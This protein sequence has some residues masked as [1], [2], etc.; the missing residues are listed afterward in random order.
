M[1]RQN[2]FGR[3]RNEFDFQ[4]RVKKVFVG[5][6]LCLTALFLL[7]QLFRFKTDSGIT[8]GDLVLDVC[9]EEEF[10]EGHHELARHTT[11]DQLRNNI[12]S[13]T[14]DKSQSIAIFARTE[15]NAKEACRILQNHGFKNVHNLGVYKP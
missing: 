14:K 2:R 12:D 11:L 9:T 7:F 8:A 1:R 6:L 10:R 3:Q 15:E 4:Q 5:A 13:I